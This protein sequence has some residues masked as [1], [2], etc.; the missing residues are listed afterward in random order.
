MQDAKKSSPNENLFIVT[1]RT[2]DSEVFSSIQ[3]PSHFQDA[4]SSVLLHPNCSAWIIINPTGREIATDLFSG[5]AP[6]QAPVHKFTIRFE[7]RVHLTEVS[8]QS[9]CFRNSDW[10]ID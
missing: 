1:S 5:I 6:E 8:G 9:V 3:H 10:A 2:I 7:V 4:Q